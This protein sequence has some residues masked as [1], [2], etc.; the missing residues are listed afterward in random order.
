M[1]SMESNPNDGVAP[2]WLRLTV[3]TLM[4]LSATSGIGYITYVVATKTSHEERATYEARCHAA[5]ARN[6]EYPA[7]AIL[8][9]DSDGCRVM[10]PDGGMPLNVGWESRRYPQE[11]E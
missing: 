7:Y 9:A 5:M 8:K 6:R 2:F 4:I 3:L 10:L 11:V 1:A